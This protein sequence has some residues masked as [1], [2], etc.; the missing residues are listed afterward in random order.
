MDRGNLEG[1]RVLDLAGEPGLIAGRLL[2]DLGADVVAVEPPGGHLLRR[3]GPFQGGRADPERS[4]AW[5]AQ[6]TSKRGITL[7]LDKPRGR[8][9]FLTLAERAD[10]VIETREP[11]GLDALGIGY[12]MLRTRNPRIVVCSITAYGQ[13]GPWADRRG[14]DLTA[15]A[16][17][18]NLFPTGDPDRA[19]IRASLPTSY[20][21]AGIEAAIGVVFAWIARDAHGTG[22]HVDV[23]LQEVMMMPN[24]SNP[25]QF[26]ITK[27]RGG[28]MGPGYRVGKVFQPEIWSCRDGFV[29]FALRGG[30]ARIPGLIAMVD[31]MREDGEPPPCLADRDWK[32]YN[33]NLLSQAE[34]DEMKA[35]FTAFFATKTKAELYQAALD[36]KLM[37]APVNDPPAVLASAQ[38]AARDF[39]V[40]I[41]YEHLEAKLRHPGPVAKMKPEGARVRRRAPRI[42]EHNREIY[43]EI[44]LGEDELAALAREGVI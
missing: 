29:S 3:R 38:L 7:D 27:H 41:E 32:T 35:A 21:H 9:L 24:M 28:R 20:A 16:T 12:A 42:G 14:S 15:L 26:P 36:R 23:S 22:Q 44:G 8:E 6:S 4:L 40:E 2:G 39:F 37:L 31:Y 13:N 17:G 1:L 5:L 19:P 25:A 33:H 18:G 34:V 10:A 30:P 11:G 43:G